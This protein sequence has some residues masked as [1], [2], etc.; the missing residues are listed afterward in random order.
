MKMKTLFV[1]DL[2]GT[3]LRNDATISEYSKNKLNEFISSGVLFTVATARSVASI[4]KMLEG[5]DIELPVIEFNGGFI[6][7]LKTG[8]H[9]L[10]N[11]VNTEITKGLLMKI[12]KSKHIPF[13]SCYDGVKDNLYYNEL[14]NEGMS[15]Y[16]E[17]RIK[18]N[19]RRLNKTNNFMEVLNEKVICFTIIGKKESLMLLYEIVNK[20]HGEFIETHLIENQYSKKWFWLTIHSKK[21][22]KDYAILKLKEMINEDIEK[23]VVFG[24]NLNDVK[25][26]NIADES[27]AVMNGIEELKKI[28]TKV[29]KSN[30]DDGVVK[31]IDQ[32]LMEK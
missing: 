11:E 26:F 1:S 25:M 22:S 5:V 2:D 18:N 8:E 14:I 24:D 12:Y 31:Y 15:W 13:I 29:I 17:D 27:I 7:D 9:L 28:A 3:L 23:L 6:S 10:V 21:A 4:T 30:E 19:D 32:Q 20:D 16:Y